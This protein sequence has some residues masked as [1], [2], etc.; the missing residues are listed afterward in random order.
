[1]AQRHPYAREQFV[2]AEGLGQIIIGANI[3]RAHLVLLAVTHRQHH[4]GRLRPLA[5][6]PAHLHPIH[7]VQAQIE[8]D[9]VSCS[10]AANASP[11]S[12]VPA[13]L[14]RN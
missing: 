2:D 13:V 1:V 14:T 10:A 5:Q 8:D 6:V 7:I 11:C 12:P 9:E 3:Q 4:H